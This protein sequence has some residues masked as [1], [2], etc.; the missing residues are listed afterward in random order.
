MRTI[1]KAPMLEIIPMNADPLLLSLDI[2][3]FGSGD[4]WDLSQSS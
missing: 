1:Y 2:S 3:D 4:E